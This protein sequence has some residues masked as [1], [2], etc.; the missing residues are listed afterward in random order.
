MTPEAARKNK[1]SVVNSYYSILIL[2]RI[3]AGFPFDLAILRPHVRSVYAG[4]VRQDVLFVVLMGRDLISH[5]MVF[6]IMVIIR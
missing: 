2:C 3:L 6:S 1:K 5:E 4:I